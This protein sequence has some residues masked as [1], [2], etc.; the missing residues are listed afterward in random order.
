MIKNWITRCISLL[1][2][3]LLVSCTLPEVTPPV[4]TAPPTEP[5]FI[6]TSTDD[7][8]PTTLPI[9]EPVEITNKNVAALAAVNRSPVNNIQQL[10]WS[11]AG[12]N[13][14]VSSQN[15]DSTGAQLFGAAILSVPNLTPVNIF[16]T[17]SGRISDIA[18]DGNRIAIISTD[19]TSLFLIDLSKGNEPQVTLTPG[20]LVGNATFS[21][22]G[23]LLALAKME[24]W[25]VDLYSTTDG[26]LTGTLTGFETAAPIYNAGFTQSPQWMVWF[27]RATLQLQEIQT[28]AMAPVMSHED[29]VTAYAMTRDGSMLASIASRFVSDAA[30]PAISL[31]D[32]AQGVELKTLVL[33][34]GAACLDFSPNGSLLAVGV[35]NALQIWDVTSGTML[36]SLAEHSGQITHLAFSAD[37]K[38]IATA[39]N[40]NQLYLWQV[41]Q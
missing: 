21:P 30:V 36:V 9:P 29:F 4:E 18:S 25:E 14:T 32:A 17:P 19:L 37:G 20:Y 27:A 8:T 2:I 5:S 26:L 35:D 13:L 22:D 28:G 38:Y 41:S 31:W 34:A 1:T 33:S 23:S 40:D 15:A 12:S 10:K 11:N 39:G 24:A 7:S 6:E 16:S 3:F